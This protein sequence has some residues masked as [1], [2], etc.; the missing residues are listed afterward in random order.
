MITKFLPN[1]VILS[2]Y[3]FAICIHY[4]QNLNTF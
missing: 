3:F 2:I 1:Q 4:V